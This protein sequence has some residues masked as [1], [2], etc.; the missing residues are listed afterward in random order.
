MPSG[1][2]RR[3]SLPSQREREHC[4][5]VQDGSVRWFMQS[6]QY[7]S[8]WYGT[9]M[10]SGW[11]GTVHAVRMVR[12]GSCSQDGTARFSA[13]GRHHAS[14]CLSLPCPPPHATRGERETSRK[15]RPSARSSVV[16]SEASAAR[17]LM[18][19]ARGMCL[20]LKGL[21]QWV[22]LIRG[23]SSAIDLCMT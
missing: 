20:W 1:L 9:F 17:V 23:G 5:T 13:A 15:L 3:G 22:P 7:W 12:H 21:R 18:A 16:I 6:V 14:A 4:G 8:G 10:Q 19:A 11:Y 2:V